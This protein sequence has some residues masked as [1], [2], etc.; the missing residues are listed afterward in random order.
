MKSDDFDDDDY[1]EDPYYFPGM[2]ITAG[3]MDGLERLLSIPRERVMSIDTETTGLDPDK[4]EILSLSIVD[5]NGKVLFDSLIRPE[6][7]K[8]WPKAAEVNGILWKDVKEKP[9]LL[10]HKDELRELASKC[11]LVVG[12]N[13]KFDLGMLYSGGISEFPNINNFDVMEEYAPVRGSWDEYHGDYRWCKLTTC[14]KHYH[15]K[16]DPHKSAEDARATVEC[17]YALLADEGY[18]APLRKRTE[19]QELAKKRKAAEESRQDIPHKASHMVSNRNVNKGN[20]SPFRLLQ[21][22]LVIMAIVSFLGII[23]LMIHGDITGAVIDIFV[24]IASVV[25]ASAVSRRARG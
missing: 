22:F 16:F 3:D 21:A 8:R 5:G 9:T 10:D 25:A 24:C 15:V 23:N 19:E 6:T 12:Y 2:T 14:A 18:I 17:F 13:V 1:E 7:R 11:D 4:D 20:P